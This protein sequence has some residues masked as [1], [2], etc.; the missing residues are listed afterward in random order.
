MKLLSTLFLV[1]VLAACSREKVPAGRIMVKNDSRD[2]EYNVIEVSA[3]GTDARLAPDEKILLPRGTSNFTVR[4]QY[5]DYVRFY[6]V[7]CPEVKGSG[8]FIKLI[9]IHVNRI[10]GDCETISAGKS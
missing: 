8:I 6:A 7:R 3:P 10:A 5:K 2:S 9:D 4:R 1:L